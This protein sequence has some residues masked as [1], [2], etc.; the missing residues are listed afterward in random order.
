M[1]GA[2]QGRACLVT[3]ATQGIGREAALGLARQGARV[4]LVGRDP[5]RAEAA[6]AYVRAGAP[7]AQV[8]AFVADLS[9]TREVLR[10]AGE[11]KARFDALHVLVNNA[12]A[13][14]EE[15]Q[16]TAE[17][18]ERTFAL[19]HLG[20]FLLT[21]ELSPLL[22]ASAPARVVNVA[23]EAHRAGRLDLAD[24]QAERGYRGIRVYGTSKL[25][26]I[27]FTV[28]LARRLEGSGVTA[29]ALHPGVVASGFG[30]NNT[31]LVRL[32]YKLGA[33]FLIS[34]EKGARTVLHVA[35]S[36]EGGR[37]SGRYF[38]G[39]RLATPSRAATD[40]QAARALWEATAGLLG[41]PS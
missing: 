32:F 39:S 38:K 33:P 29:N 4:G 34:P 40:T 19:N 18:F 13:I 2:M 14:F 15:R 31:G 25:M 16:V 20:Y 21:H 11:V 23:S 9:D 3:G 41:V 24:L 6:A 5:Q 12:G 37:V 36:E 17:G 26:N 22:R 28:E 7:G 1:S 10:L 27:L 8:E 30:L 35:A